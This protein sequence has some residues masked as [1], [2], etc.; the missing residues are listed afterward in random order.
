MHMAKLMSTGTCGCCGSD[1]SNQATPMIKSQRTHQNTALVC[2][3]NS[4]I[5][6][7][8]S[9]VLLGLSVGPVVGL[10]LAGTVPQP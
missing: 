10:G 7:G 2:G 9:G 3:L 8:A 6:Q 1:T 5:R 4:D